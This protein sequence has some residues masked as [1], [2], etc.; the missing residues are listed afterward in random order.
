MHSGVKFLEFPYATANTFTQTL[1]S[2][3]QQWQN[4]TMGGHVKTWL[5]LLSRFKCDYGY[6][7]VQKH[8]YI[9]TKWKSLFT[10]LLNRKV[11]DYAPFTFV[12]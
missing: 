11:N 2:D 9:T 5:P 4:K 1:V 12:W 3:T 7:D 6:T 10:N 8:T